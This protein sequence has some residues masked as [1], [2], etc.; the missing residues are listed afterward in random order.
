[1]EMPK[2]DLE[3]PPLRRTA[4]HLEEELEQAQQHVDIAEAIWD[5][6]IKRYQKAVVGTVTRRELVEVYDHTMRVEGRWMAACAIRD[7][8][9]DDVDL[10]SEIVDLADIFGKD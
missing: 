7:R 3:V 2:L 1:M 9:A 5:V 4:F 10:I 6:A 8:I